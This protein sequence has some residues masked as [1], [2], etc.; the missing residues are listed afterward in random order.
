V[1]TE[2]TLRSHTCGQL[3]AE[4]VDTRVT[5]C[6]WVANS[7]DH[8]GL[9]FVDLR[10]R[11]GLTQCVFDPEI[12]PEAHAT[13]ERVR[14]EWSLRVTGRVRPRPEGM[15]NPKMDT[16]Q[17]ELE[18]TE[19]LVLN[20]SQ[21]PPFEISA[22]SEAGEDLRLKYRFL[23]LRRPQMRDAL[24]TRFRIIKAMRDFYDHEDF[25]DIET[26]FLT[27]STPEGARDFLVPS[28]VNP[29]MFFAL[30]QSPQL[31]KQILMISGFDRYY[32]IVR[33]MRDEDLRADR[34]PEFTQLDVEMAYVTAE[35]VIDCTERMIAHVMKEILSIE[36]SLPLPRMTY[37]EAML[38]Y[39]NDAPDTRFEMLI[40][41]ITEL[42]AGTDFRVFKQVVESGGKVRGLCA[43]G[44]AAMSRKDIDDLAPYVATFGAKGLA[45]MKVTSE[46]LTG[47]IAK[48]FSDQQKQSLLKTFAASEGDLLMFVADKESVVCRSLGELREHLGEK[49]GL[50]DEGQF[51]YTWV[52]DFPMFE[53]DEEQKRYISI[54]HPFTAAKDEDLDSLESDPLG[55]KA[56]AYDIVLN[57]TELGGGSIRIHQPDVQQRVFRLLGID[58]AEAQLK[59]GFLLEALKYG[60]PPHGGIALGM[61]RLVMLLLGL[62][63]IRD[64]I[65]FPKTQRA[66]C[67]MT[68][69]PGP[70]DDAQ[71]DDLH[72]RLAPEAKA[73]QQ[74]NG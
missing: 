24:L 32:Q 30:P 60:A 27:K 53:F 2:T 56:K 72:I 71:L 38:R 45:W 67:L 47:P 57:G 13:A 29:A 6:G 35:D 50:I 34:Q 5:L 52:V 18:A 8:G 55:A 68:G 48:F 51:S 69:A 7:R 23:D 17:I 66:V 64:T 44:G 42:A 3:R 22:E 65:A 54:H 15:V 20:E 14:G 31:F 33:C 37:D 12:S 41:D 16:G 4:D 36:V 49:L 61:D 40:E 70:V 58:E 1:P 26:P 73:G 11:Y 10:D 63:N 9:I 46:G 28:R 19:L 21:T 25:I 39:G 43:I 74:E 62:S 59:F